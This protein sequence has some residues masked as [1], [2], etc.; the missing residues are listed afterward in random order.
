[1]SSPKVSADSFLISHIP[2]R[3]SLSAFLLAN[4]AQERIEQHL[5]DYRQGEIL[6][7]GVKLAIFGP[8][9]AGKSSLLNFLGS[10]GH[11]TP[12]VHRDVWPLQRSG[13]QPSLQIYPE[14]R[15]T[16]W[17]FLLTLAACR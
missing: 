11:S 17:S 14:L 16:F 9:N 8:P 5:K 2:L 6:R 12:P 4:R 1:M 15:V 3:C 7:S 10:F 13:K